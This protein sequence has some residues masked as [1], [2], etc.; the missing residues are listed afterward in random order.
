MT[1]GIFNKSEEEVGF[2]AKKKLRELVINRDW[3]KG[4]GICVSFCPKKVLE[5]DSREK[6]IAARPE[7]CICCSLCELR[8][9]DLAIE[10][11]I[12]EEDNNE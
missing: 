4:C 11:L 6:A 7:E 3:C 2:M 1:P 8:C 9:P 5:L 12:D 10:V